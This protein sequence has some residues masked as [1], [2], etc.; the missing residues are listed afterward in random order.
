MIKEE[1]MSLLALLIGLLMIVAGVLLTSF[2]LLLRDKQ[3][4]YTESAGANVPT[5]GDCYGLCKGDSG[6]PSV[7]CIGLC[8]YGWP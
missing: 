7:T 5:Y 8:A 6:E 1:S 2:L 3:E 4:E